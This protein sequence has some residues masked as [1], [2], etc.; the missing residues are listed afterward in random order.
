MEF[1]GVKVDKKYDKEK[2]RLEYIV[3][4]HQKIFENPKDKKKAFYDAAL[5]FLN[6]IQKIGVENINGE[7]ALII[8]EKSRGEFESAKQKIIYEAERQKSNM[9][10]LTNVP[11]PLKALTVGGAFLGGTAGIYFCYPPIADLSLYTSEK[12]NNISSNFAVVSGLLQFLISGAGLIIPGVFGVMAGEV[13]GL[14]SSYLYLNPKNPLAKKYD[15]FLKI[16]NKID[17]KHQ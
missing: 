12:I 4:E 3:N 17:L 7:I 9:K 5:Y 16:N 11:M 15:D 10:K 8:G 13:P 1:D 6:D 2:N 14:A